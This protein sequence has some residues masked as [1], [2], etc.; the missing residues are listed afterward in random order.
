[1]TN[2]DSTADR[3]VLDAA[4]TLIHTR[5]HASPKRLGDPGPDREQIEKILSAAGAARMN[6]RFAS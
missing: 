2:I 6:S 1:L 3:E 5:Q 4:L